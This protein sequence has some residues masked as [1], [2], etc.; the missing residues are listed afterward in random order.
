MNYLILLYKTLEQIY[1]KAIKITIESII[2]DNNYFCCITR[3]FNQIANEY[4]FIHFS[5]A[6]QR[7]M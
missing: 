4:E 6:N 7:K 3:S 1:Q 2:N 5:T